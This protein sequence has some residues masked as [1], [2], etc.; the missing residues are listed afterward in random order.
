MNKLVSQNTKSIIKNTHLIQRLMEKNLKLNIE[1]LKILN[2]EAV[3][4]ITQFASLSKFYTDSL[5]NKI[6]KDK[7]KESINNF[8]K[9]T[10]EK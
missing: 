10:R 4:S 6:I 5:K 9:T 8:L 3:L 7:K 2:K 1:I